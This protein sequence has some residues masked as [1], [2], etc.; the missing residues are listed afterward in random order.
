MIP[1]I[2]VNKVMTHALISVPSK[3]DVKKAVQVMSQKDVGSL[4][5]QKDDQYIGIITENDIVKKV[6]AKDMDPATTLVDDIMSFPIYSID[7]N[8]SLNTA[9][10]IMGEQH[11]RH[12]LVTCQEKPTGILSVRNLLDSVYEWSLRIRL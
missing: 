8:E 1:R 11:I 3:T 10:E 6:M 7:E 2:S 12:L 4:L 9:N 5:I